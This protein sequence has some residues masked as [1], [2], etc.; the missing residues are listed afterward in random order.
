MT[1]CRLQLP[2]NQSKKFLSA[3]YERWYTYSASVGGS[4]FLHSSA[5]IQLDNENY[6]ST[7]WRGYFGPAFKGSTE[8]LREILDDYSAYCSEQNILF[9]MMRLDPNDAVFDSIQSSK[10]PMHVSLLPV[11][12]WLYAASQR[13]RIYIMQLCPVIVEGTFGGHEINSP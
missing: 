8:H 3:V 7:T 9:E 12:T 10:A 13:M 4:T 11:T 1:R 5:K 2:N 6:F